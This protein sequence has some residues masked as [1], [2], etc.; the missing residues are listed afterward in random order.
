MEE[1]EIKAV[2]R[3]P[4]QEVFD[5]LTDVDKATDWNPAAVEVRKSSAGPLGVGSTLVYVARFL[6][7][8]SESS[9]EVTKFDPGLRYTTKTI[10]GPFH[11]EVDTTLEAVGND[12]SLT[13]VYRGESRGFFKLAEPIVVRLVKRQF[14]TSTEMLRELLEADDR[15]G[16]DR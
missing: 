3:R 4:T 16:P 6:G 12:T 11:L 15:A 2:I 7:R 14:E 9:V 8:Q 1:F 13:T 5:Y 10:S